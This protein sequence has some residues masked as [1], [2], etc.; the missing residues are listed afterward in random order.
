MDVAIRSSF[1]IPALV[2]RETLAFSKSK[3]SAS[4]R[5][6]SASIAITPING[7][8]TRNKMTQKL[9]TYKYSSDPACRDHVSSRASSKLDMIIEIFEQ[10][11]SK[12]EG[13]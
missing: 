4:G 9:Y 6:C 12:T 2:A 5:W 10:L 7:P 3:F 8:G 13:P 1:C 11:I